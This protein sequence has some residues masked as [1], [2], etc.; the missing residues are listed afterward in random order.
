LQQLISNIT[1][2]ISKDQ[3]DP[4]LQTT[5]SDLET[6]IGHELKD[7]VEA[8]LYNSA[9]LNVQLAHEKNY[10]VI[11]GSQLQLLAQANIDFGML[12]TTAKA[13]YDT[14]KSTNPEVYRSF[15]F[16]QWFG[17]LQGG[18]LITTAPNGN[19]VLTNYGRGFLKYI[20]DRHLSVNKSY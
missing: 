18:G 20:L 12:P 19:Y 4:S 17:F 13:I 16:E 9:S 2:F 5:R 10:N 1:A 3:L 15:T 8:L 6:K 11:F 14:A 7:Q